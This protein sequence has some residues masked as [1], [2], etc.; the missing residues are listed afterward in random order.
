M[1]A[2]NIRRQKIYRLAEHAGFGLDTA[3][4]PADDA[5]AVDHRGV[6]VGTNKRVGVING[7]L[8][9]VTSRENALRKILEVHL[10][11]DADAGRDNLEGVE[12]LHAPFEELVALP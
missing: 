11:H 3:H 5:D 2:D 8:S 10:M 1:H 7:R 6:R 12:G 4:A 9:I